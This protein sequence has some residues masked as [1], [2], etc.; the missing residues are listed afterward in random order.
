MRRRKW[1][2]FKTTSPP[3][4]VFAGTVMPPVLKDFT[5]IQNNSDHN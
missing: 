3:R 4:R 2:I 1:A 5:L